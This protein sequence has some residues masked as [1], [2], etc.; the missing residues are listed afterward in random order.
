VFEKYDGVRGF[1]NPVKK[2]F[3]SRSGNELHLPSEIINSMP[4][5]I[6]LDGELWYLYPLTPLLS[7]IPF[8]PSFVKVWKR[9]F[10]GIR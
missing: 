2:T 6:F 9:K 10:P 1:W 7:F 5:D 3:S 8:L 4:T